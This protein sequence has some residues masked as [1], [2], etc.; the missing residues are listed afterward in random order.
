[1]PLHIPF[2]GH[3]SVR[4]QHLRLVARWI[5]TETGTQRRLRNLTHD[6]RAHHVAGRGRADSID[7]SLNCS[8]SRSGH[9]MFHP[10]RRCHLRNC[11]SSFQ[12]GNFQCTRWQPRSSHCSPF[13]ASTIPSPQKEVSPPTNRQSALQTLQARSP[14]SRSRSPHCCHRRFHCRQHPQCHHRNSASHPQ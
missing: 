2:A 10:H 6:Y 9:R 14:Y 7:T 3:R 1:M 11:R 13:P 5:V 12:V 4:S 8:R